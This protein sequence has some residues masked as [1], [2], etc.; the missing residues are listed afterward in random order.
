MNCETYRRYIQWRSM[1][2]IT[3]LR[4]QVTLEEQFSHQFMKRWL[5]VKVRGSLKLIIETGLWSVWGTGSWP[6]TYNSFLDTLLKCQW[7]GTISFQQNQNFGYW[8]QVLYFWYR[9]DWGLLIWWIAVPRKQVQGFRGFGGEGIICK[10]H[11]W[12][13]LLIS[14]CVPKHKWKQTHTHTL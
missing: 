10:F 11:Y 13:L 14:Y 1:L 5:D 3:T 9:E 4:G 6:S 7:H 2:H 12:N 8:G